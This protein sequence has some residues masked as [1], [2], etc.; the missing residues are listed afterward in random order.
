MTGSI[1]SALALLAY[2]APESTFLPW[3]LPLGM[4]L[5]IVFAASTGKKT[6][7]RQ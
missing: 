2:T 4:G 7:P 3:S 6:S 5:G 1:I